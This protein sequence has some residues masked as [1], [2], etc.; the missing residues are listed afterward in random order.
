MFRR[1]LRLL[2]PS[3]LVYGVRVGRA[4]IHPAKPSHVRGVEMGNAKGAI[5]RN[6]GIHRKKGGA[7]GTARRSTGVH[8][9]KHNA[10]LPGIMPNWSPG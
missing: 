9:L 1:L 5:F 6:A 3:V 10:I 8:P 7:R 4:D 2:T